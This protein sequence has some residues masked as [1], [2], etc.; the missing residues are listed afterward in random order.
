MIKLYPDNV[1]ISFYVNY[2]SLRLIV[3]RQMLSHILSYV[4]QTQ[5]CCQLAIKISKYTLKYP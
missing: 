2:N 4:Q 5:K 1:C 3:K